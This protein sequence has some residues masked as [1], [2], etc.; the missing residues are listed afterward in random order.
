[1]LIMLPSTLSFPKLPNCNYKQWW[2]DMEARLCILSALC[3]VEGIEIR[4]SFVKPLNAGECYDL[5]NFNTRMDLAAR[6][7]WSCIE[8]EQQSH[9]ET[10]RDD[11][12]A[13]WAKLKAVHMQK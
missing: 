4:P 13:M 10:I 8:V 11:P 9:L 12:I 1:M 6:E 7:T 3:I 5:C 2:L